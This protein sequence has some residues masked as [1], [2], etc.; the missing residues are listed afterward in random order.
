MTTLIKY[1]SVAGINYTLL[2]ELDMLLC[3]TNDLVARNIQIRWGL[4]VK[5]FEY[6]DPFWNQCHISTYMH[7]YFIL[8]KVKEM[9]M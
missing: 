3:S 7:L 6:L 2:V 5:L 8:S 4:L 9:I 1:Y